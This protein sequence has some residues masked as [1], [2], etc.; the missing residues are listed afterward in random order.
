MIAEEVK[1]YYALI[2]GFNTF[3]Y[4]HTLHCGKKHFCCYS[5][6]AFSTEQTLKRHIK[7]CF[8]GNGKKIIILPKKREY[9]KFKIY[10]RKINSPFIT[11]ADFE[12]I[13][14]PEDK[15]KQNP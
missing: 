6:Q 5:L 9:V 14:V 3:I 4:D 13:L 2:K 15:K 11:D 1:R 7:D 10:K 8:K 12:S